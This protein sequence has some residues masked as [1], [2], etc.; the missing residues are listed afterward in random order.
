MFGL[1]CYSGFSALYV[2]VECSEYRAS[3]GSQSMCELVLDI[4]EG[5]FCGFIQYVL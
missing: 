2:T 3:E 1:R 5:L 4:E